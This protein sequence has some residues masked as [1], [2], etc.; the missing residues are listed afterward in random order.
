MKWINTA[1][2]AIA[3]LSAIVGST[4]Y[5]AEISG[6]SEALAAADRAR[7]ERQSDKLKLLDPLIVDVAVIKE[8]V[9]TINEKLDRSAQARVLHE[10]D[11]SDE[12]EIETVLQ[13]PT[14]TH[15]KQA[16]RRRSENKS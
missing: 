5:L 16:L 10:T 14:Q 1:S 15:I 3:I 8:Q 13:T 11:S 2:A 7:I 12:E 9:K 6:R 4:W